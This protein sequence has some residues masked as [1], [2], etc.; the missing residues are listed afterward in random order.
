MKLIN[1]QDNVEKYLSKKGIRIFR[2]LAYL[3][4]YLNA[5][6]LAGNAE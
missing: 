3:V 1:S 4:Q 2:K 6:I 5:K